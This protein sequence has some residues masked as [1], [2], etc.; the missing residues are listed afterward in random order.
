MIVTKIVCGFGNQLFCYACGYALAKRKKT[1]LL[2][3]A[4]T[5]DKAYDREFTLECLNI[6]APVIR[7]KLPK[8]LRGGVRLCLALP[9]KYYHERVTRKADELVVT[10]EVGKNV[11][12]SGYWQS[13]KYFEDCKEEIR[14]QFTP[15]Q[16]SESAQRIIQQYKMGE[17]IAVHIRRSDFL[18]CKICLNPEYYTKA[19]SYMKKEIGNANFIFFSDDM[20][21]AKQYF[22]EKE[23]F[24]YF[25][26]AEDMTDLD[27]FFAVS[28]CKHQIIANSTWSWWA[29]WLNGNEGKVICYPKT[30]KEDQFYPDSWIGIA[31]NYL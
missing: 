11:Y 26:K 24:Q 29:A 28:A 9:R 16:L 6:E 10:G 13:E 19:I 2:V 1:R 3:D 17:T 18:D 31:A 8:V 7:L 25:E 12:L 5:Y 21:W 23:E 4:L 15:K 30:E 22:G 20:E 14:R 27:E